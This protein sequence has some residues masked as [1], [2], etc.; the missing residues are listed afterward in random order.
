[1]S[2]RMTQEDACA[3]ARNEHWLSRPEA[4]GWFAIWLIRFVGLHFGRTFTRLVLSH[5]TL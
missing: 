3:Q 4:G 5:I 1:M 2:A